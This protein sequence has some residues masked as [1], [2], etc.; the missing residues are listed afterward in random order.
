M[1]LTK[2]RRQWLASAVECFLA[3]TYEHRCMLIVADE[4]ADFEGIVP[5]DPRIRVELAPT[6]I[7]G[8]KRNLACDLVRTE[9]IAHIDDDDWYGPNR[10][11]DQIT[12]LLDSGKSA[13]GYHSAKMTT[14]Q[15]WWKY[16][17]APQFSLGASLVY[18]RDYWQSNHFP[19]VRIAEDNAW[20]DLAWHARQLITADASKDLEPRRTDG[21]SMI[22][23]M[24]PGNTSPKRPMSNWRP[25]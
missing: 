19:E 3:Q 18:H 21:D 14:G 4:P 13:T 25:L 24:H 9:L 12:R 8:L 1:C 5:V 15:R 10:L 16:Q 23:N 11:T 7:T 2:G 17:G 22:V 20:V 6:R